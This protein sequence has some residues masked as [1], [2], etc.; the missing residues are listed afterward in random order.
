MTPQTRKLQ[1]ALIDIGHQVEANDRYPNLEMVTV[2]W[3]EF[4]EAVRRDDCSAIQ[5]VGTA[6]CAE[7]VK[8]MMERA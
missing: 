5:K 1:S 8:F 2:L 4:A 3:R 6:L 7:V